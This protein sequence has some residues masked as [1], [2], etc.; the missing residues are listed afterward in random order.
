MCWEL[1]HVPPGDQECRRK[2][3]QT[4]SYSLVLSLQFLLLCYD[5]FVNAFSELLRTA[6]V[7]QL[8]LFM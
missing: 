1:W 2:M 3:L 4:S 8:V 6:S 7:I 5:L